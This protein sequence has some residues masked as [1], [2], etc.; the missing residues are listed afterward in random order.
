MNTAEHLG[1]ELKSQIFLLGSWW[2]PK[3]RQK[4]SEHWICQVIWKTPNE[5]KCFC[6]HSHIW[7]ISRV[8]GLGIHQ[9]CPFTHAAHSQRC[10]CE[11]SSHFY[12]KCTAGENIINTPTRSLLILR[13]ITCSSHT[14]V[15]SNITQT[16][17]QGAAYCLVRLIRTFVFTHT[18]LPGI[19]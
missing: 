1:A 12:W 18:A 3:Q 14:R 2:R 7:T 11:V 16:L 13:T 4:E 17:Y 5:C 15:H 19:V 6:S 8:W 10:P 9:Y